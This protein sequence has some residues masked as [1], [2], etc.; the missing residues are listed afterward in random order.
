MGKWK[1]RMA[2][3][4]AG[5]IGIM[6]VPTGAIAASAAELE[7][8]SEAMPLASW[9]DVPVATY[10]TST[11]ELYYTTEYDGTLTITGCSRDA[12]EV[13]IPAE[14]D[15]IPVTTIQSDAFR[16]CSVTSVTIPETICSLPEDVFEECSPAE[17]HVSEENQWYSSEDNVLMNKEKTRLLRFCPADSRTAYTVPDSVTAI[18]YAAFQGCSNLI[19]IDIPSSVTY[20]SSCVFWDC[21]GLT[22]VTLPEK[23]SSINY[24]TF[25]GCSALRECIIPSNVTSIDMDAFYGC[26]SLTSVTIPKKVKYIGSSA[27]GWCGSLEKVVI[28]NANCNIADDEYTFTNY[29]MSSDFSGTIYGYDD[30]TAQ[31]YAE[32]YG[33]TF[34]SLG[35]PPLATE[36]GETGSYDGFRYEVQYDRSLMIIRC[37]DTKTQIEIPEEIEGM[38][39]SG[40][41]NEALQH[42]TELESLAISK[43]VIEIEYAALQYCDSLRTITVDEENPCY[44]SQKNVLFRR[45]YGEDEKQ[46]AYL[47]RYCPQDPRAEYSIPATVT[48]IQDGAFRNCGNLTA[49][50]IPESVSNIGN[51]AFY[52]CSSLESV[53]IAKN[54]KSIG[55]QAFCNCASLNV[56]TVTSYNCSIG[57]YDAVFTN[58]S[59]SSTFDGTIYGY[60]NSTAETYAEIYGVSFV[61]LGK[62]PADARIGETGTVGAL[63]YEVL[64]NATIAIT[65]CD[66]TA[67]TVEIPDEIDGIAVTQIRYSAFYACE[68]LTSITIPGSITEIQSSAFSSC[69]SLKEVVIPNGI[70]EIADYAFSYCTSLTSVS[71]PDS[72][73]AIGYYAF[74]GCTSLTDIKIP[75]S[76]KEIG[77][78]A[79]QDVPWM[80]E[81][82]EEFVVL[83]DGVFYAYNGTA[84]KITLPET[85][86]ALSQNAFHVTYLS[87]T[88]EM[89]V[90]VPFQEITLSDNV[91]R[92]D[93]TWFEEWYN[94]PVTVNLGK[95]TKQVDFW[96][97]DKGNGYWVE[98]VNAPADSLYF[99]SDD[100]I[101]YNKNQ[102]KLVY[103][104][105]CKED[106]D[107][108]KLPATVTE[109]GDG[110][111][112]FSNL[113][114]MELTEQITKI[115]EYAFAN[116]E[117]QFGNLT[118]PKGVTT[119]PT[120]AF[121]G[122]NI[123]NLTIPQSVTTIED[124]AFMGS[125]V[126]SVHLP[127]GLV[128]L[129][130]DVFNFC[131]NLTS[132]IIPDSVTE[133]EYSVFWE[134]T[135][136]ESI[137]IPSSVTKIGWSAF[138]NCTSLTDVYYTGTQAEWDA[139]TIDNENDVLKT[140][141]VHYE[142]SPAPEETEAET[143]DLDGNDSIDTNDAYLCL[144]A[145][146][147]LSVGNTSGLTE[148]QEKAADVDGD[149]A[150]TT[151]DA[152]YILLYYAKH[153]VGNDVS[154]TELLG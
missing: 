92:I 139:I 74:S 127:D 125:T 93:L 115:G 81:Q 16:F 102:T 38:P 30:S 146:A 84:Q 86:K 69:A 152:Y 39:V 62:A 141:T 133:L 8:H 50:A 23:I 128:S 63:S 98:A 25:I 12:S 58:N 2:V 110:A 145:Y 108:Y 51:E 5:V 94:H 11:C 112:F 142:S 134:C 148:A 101:L 56:V 143:G 99:S 7:W 89:E 82:T 126:Q 44:V 67:T 79:F 14:I 124:M 43:N 45:E 149:G 33:R 55:N 52:E 136:L 87:D 9:D 18:G 90:S 17:I 13:V 147:K 104:P 109:I 64:E 119:I 131:Q 150:I 91:E 20:I 3:I 27:F 154:W 132:I 122:C 111:F 61:S 144:F 138:G 49:I 121:G 65:N 42:C 116:S 83:G 35:E 40:I 32:Q 95:R 137:T 113:S 73:T 151:N 120:K 140:A 60:D 22:A 72:V 68:N 71:I 70:T 59:L 96:Y 88:E 66:D 129:Q 114:K 76:V 10:T 19:S 24:A 26:S 123:T 21:A 47:L 54:V 36:V 130:S 105:L 48:S 80:N 31:K 100:G 28:E 103:Y 37:D 1:Q 53:T 57:G 46:L 4:T 41:S 135:A 153:S 118:I 78:Y 85:V 77:N 97:G 106:L 34:V 117:I 75:D 107:E 6:G 15:G 29:D